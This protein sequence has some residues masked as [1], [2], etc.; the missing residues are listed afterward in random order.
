MVFHL[1]LVLEHGFD[2]LFV[3]GQ[4]QCQRF[5]KPSVEGELLAECDFPECFRYRANLARMSAGA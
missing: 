4:F 1:V 5:V 3:L 2:E